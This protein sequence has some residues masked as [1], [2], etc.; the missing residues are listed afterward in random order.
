LPAPRSSLV[1]RER[2]VEELLDLI[3]TGAERLITLTGVGGCGKTRLALE[4][5]RHLRE[6]FPDGVWLVDLA[7]V[8]DP[9]QVALRVAGALSVSDTSEGGLASLQ[10]RT[11]LLVLDNCEHLVEACASLA[12]HLLSTCADVRILAT[13]REPLLIAGER[14][15]RVPPLRAPEPGLEPTLAALEGCPSVQLFVERAGEIAP[16]FQLTPDN[17]AAITRICTLVDGIPLAIE[18]AAAQARVL[19]PAEIAARLGD[20]MQLLAS[21]NRLAPTRQQTLRASLDWS[22]ALLSPQQ[23]VVFRRLAVFAGTWSLQAAEAVCADDGLAPA[24]VLSHLTRVVDKSL[25]LPVER[26]GGLVYRLLEPVRQ[27]AAHRLATSGELES[28][29]ARHARYCIDLAQH[30]ER[31]LT[32]PHQ[33]EWLRKVES[34]LDGIRAVLSRAEQAGDG[35]TILS[36][37]G[38]LYYFLWLRRHLRE[39]RHWFEAG[40]ACAEEVPP[41]LRARGLFGLTLMVSLIRENAEAEFFGQQALAAFQELGDS[42]A[43]ALVLVIVAQTSLAGGDAKRAHRLAEDARRHAIASSAQWPLGHALILLGHVLHREGDV[44]RAIELEGQAL[45]IFERDGDSW[46]RAFALAS[47]ASMREPGSSVAHV[48]GL[49]NVRWCWDTRDLPALAS[50]L[51]YLALYGGLQS[52]ENHVRLCAA[53]HAVRLSVGVPAAPGERDDVERHLRQSRAQLGDAAFQDVWNAAREVP[54]EQLVAE[55]LSHPQPL[56]PRGV[57]RGRGEALTPR[58]REVALLLLEGASDR[59]IAQA[60]T[61]TEGTA[62]LHVHHVLA[63]LGLRSRA[64]VADRAMAAGLVLPD[65]LESSEIEKI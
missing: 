32:G 61:I 39:G 13:S 22:Y 3:R 4:V 17:A 31:E 59:K 63:K 35:S 16:G 56:A 53:A 19:A 50:A 14:Q 27:Y 15:R 36:I 49:A 8:S 5:A 33:A 47:I 46:S 21:A 24:E 20:C 28:A 51:E 60:L 40:L 55:V 12:D 62:G 34:E 42:A 43:Q 45:G 37:A 52:I 18:L 57:R 6:Y 9:R 58:E 1:G 54:T 10:K 11:L 23:Q 38:P 25:V 48:A 29:Q 65:D 26:D 41:Q 2:E 7:P 44:A 64:Q 30:A